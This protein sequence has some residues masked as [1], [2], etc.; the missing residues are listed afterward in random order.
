MRDNMGAEVMLQR[1]PWSYFLT[2]NYFTDQ[3]K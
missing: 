3:L 1:Q 2:P